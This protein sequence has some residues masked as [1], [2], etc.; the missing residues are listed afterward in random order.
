[1]E[2]SIC[3]CNANYYGNTCESKVYTFGKNS[4]LKYE[5]ITPVTHLTLHL[6][7]KEPVRIFSFKYK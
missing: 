3:V 5:P 6:L 7:T 2:N 4:L 1:M